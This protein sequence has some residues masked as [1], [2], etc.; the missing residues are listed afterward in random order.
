MALRH[1]AA[2]P[3]D[4]VATFRGKAQ[5][6]NV[7]IPSAIDYYTQLE[8]QFL[9]E[10]EQLQVYATE[11]SLDQAWKDKIAYA[12]RN[13]GHEFLKVQAQGGEAGVNG[14]PPITHANLFTFGGLRNHVS[15][16][17]EDLYELILPD[18]ERQ[19][20]FHAAHQLRP[21]TFK[22]MTTRQ[23]ETAV[24]LQKS[25]RTFR[26]ALSQTL[27]DIEDDRKLLKQAISH[28]EMIKNALYTYRVGWQAGD[29]PARPNNDA[30]N[31]TDANPA[32]DVNQGGNNW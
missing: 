16:L 32:P 17:C 10:I 5:R 11:A 22:V 26:P 27:A 14:N 3:E 23:R 21:I 29:E 9:K 18:D 28:L 13:I 1:R 31:N 30:N 7:V 2:P 12:E 20:G 25:L 8:I 6:L 24:S 15:D 19:H 4:T